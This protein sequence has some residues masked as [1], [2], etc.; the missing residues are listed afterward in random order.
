M[1]ATLFNIDEPSRA[2]SAQLGLSLRS[3]VFLALLNK[4]WITRIDQQTHTLAVL[5]A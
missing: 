1:L 2:N 4:G 3:G 5:D